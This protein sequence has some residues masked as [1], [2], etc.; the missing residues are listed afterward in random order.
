MPTAPSPRRRLIS[1]V[2]EAYVVLA[3]RLLI[4]GLDCVLDRAPISSVS[5]DTSCESPLGGV[6]GGVSESLV[7]D[8]IPRLSPLLRGLEG[9]LNC[10]FICDDSCTSGEVTFFGSVGI[11]LFGS[12]DAQFGML[13]CLCCVMLVEK[14]ER[15]IDSSSSSG[16]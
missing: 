15:L 3:L 13:L 4:C 14:E 2:L 1:S 16:S 7:S 9:V 10:V 5:S 8:T 12:L 11:G 6:D